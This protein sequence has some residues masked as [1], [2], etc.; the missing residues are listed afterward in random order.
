MFYFL[1][2]MQFKLGYKL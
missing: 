2:G 1:N